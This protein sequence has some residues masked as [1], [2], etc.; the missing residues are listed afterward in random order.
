M[1]LF[2]G[3]TGASVLLA[4]LAI[5]FWSE[6]GAAA[7][8]AGAGVYVV[9]MF[10]VTVVFNVPLNNTLAQAAAKG[11]DLDA[12]WARYLKVWTAWNH[13]RTLASTAA[14]ILFLVAVKQA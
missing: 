12:V 13:V 3:T 7:M 8:L 6:P 11:K 10:L 2:W 1:P 9:G 14:S 5:T 4:G